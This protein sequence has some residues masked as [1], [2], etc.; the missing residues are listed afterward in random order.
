MREMTTARV[1]VFSFTED[2]KN[3]VKIL[4]GN[5]SESFVFFISSHTIFLPLGSLISPKRNMSIVETP[6]DIAKVMTVTR[7]FCRFRANLWLADTADTMFL[8]DIYRIRSVIPQH[9]L[10]RTLSTFP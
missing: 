2:C 1:T 5:L 4:I 10:I 6:L 8:F 3:I 9:S 7:L